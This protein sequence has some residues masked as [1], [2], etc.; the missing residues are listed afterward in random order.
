MF[1]IRFIYSTALTLTLA[2][3]P[4]S[5]ATASKFLS[6]ENCTFK[7][8]SAIYAGGP[9]E[10]VAITWNLRT[11]EVKSFRWDHSGV[12]WYSFDGD[13]GRVQSDPPHVYYYLTSLGITTAGYETTRYSLKGYISI[14]KDWPDATFAAIYEG[15]GTEWMAAKGSVTCK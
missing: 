10:S 9:P 1:Y 7:T 15:T 14:D 3:L 5:P 6:G 12:T 4:L 8:N 13:K 2:A 11:G